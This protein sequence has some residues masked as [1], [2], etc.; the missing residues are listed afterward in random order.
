MHENEMLK[1]KVIE[2]EARL[3]QYE[4]AHTPPSL[5]RGRNRKKDQEKDIK[6]KPG[7][8][9]GHKG[10]TRTYVAPDSK[11]MSQWI[12]VPIAG[13]SLVL[14]FELIPG[15]LRKFLNL[16]RSSLLNIG[17]CT[18]DVLAAGRK[19]LQKIQAAHMKANSETT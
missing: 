5:R 14:L 12:T 19:L 7:Q 8:K 1:A 6:G 16:S 3:A 18:T 10:V 4:N 2:L 13:Q 11:W 9:S 17:S 15:S